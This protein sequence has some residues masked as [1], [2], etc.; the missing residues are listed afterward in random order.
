MSPVLRANFSGVAQ[1]GS[2]LGSYLRGRR[3]KS[4]PRNQEGFMK[5]FLIVWYYGTIGA[6]VGPLPYDQAECE[7][8]AEALIAADPQPGGVLECSYHEKRPELGQTRA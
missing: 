6:T 5:L 3:F 2:V 7:K 8:R 1:S 4:G